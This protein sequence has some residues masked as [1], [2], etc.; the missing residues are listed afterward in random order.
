M[1][2]YR[3]QQRHKLR[4]NNKVVLVLNFMILEVTKKNNNATLLFVTLLRCLDLLRHCIV[5]I[6]TAAFRCKTLMHTVD[7]YSKKLNSPISFYGCYEFLSF[8]AISHNLK[9]GGIE[10]NHPIIYHDVIFNLIY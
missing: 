6:N 3:T 5:E 10:S 8:N 4:L 7:I 2:T 9:N 1:F